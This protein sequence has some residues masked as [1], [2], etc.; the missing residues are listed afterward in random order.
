MRWMRMAIYT[1]RLQEILVAKSGSDVIRHLA[2]LSPERAASI[3]TAARNRV[4]AEHTYARRVDR[5][6][7]LLLSLVRS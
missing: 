1:G 2:N 5:L 6:E 7:T 3:G 4:L